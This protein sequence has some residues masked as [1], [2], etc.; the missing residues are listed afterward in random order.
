MWLQRKKINREQIID[1]DDHKREAVKSR[2]LLHQL[3]LIGQTAGTGE[4][5]VTTRTR[6]A[7]RRRTAVI[8]RRRSRRGSTVQTVDMEQRWSEADRQVA[9]RHLHQERMLLT[10]IVAWNWNIYDSGG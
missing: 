10:M 3:V 2:F 5:A 4:L 8:A 7:Q 6:P 9:G 1:V